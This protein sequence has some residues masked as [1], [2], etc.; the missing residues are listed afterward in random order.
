MTEHDDHELGERFHALRR[1]VAAAVPPF[2]SMLEAAL[3]R[4]HPRR[5]GRAVVATAL[6]L[7]AL[8]LILTLR[9]RHRAAVDLAGVRVHTPTDFLLQLPGADMLRTVPTLTIP[10]RGLP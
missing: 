10:G 4:P 9:G 1:E 6:T 8:V 2:R 5:F 7:V 3:A